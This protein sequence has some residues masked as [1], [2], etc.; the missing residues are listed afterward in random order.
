MELSSES[1]FDYVPTEAILSP[2]TEA[3]PEAS[4]WAMLLAGFAG[5]SVVGYR[6]SRKSAAV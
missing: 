1:G 3:V 2:V 6:R 5:L 4:T